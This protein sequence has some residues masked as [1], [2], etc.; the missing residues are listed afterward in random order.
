M[1][2]NREQWEWGKIHHY[3]WDHTFGKKSKLMGLYFNEG[4]YAAGGGS[5]TL[6]LTSYIWGKNL[7]TTIMPA[8]RLVVD[9]SKEEKVSLIS[10]PGQ[11]GHPSSSHYNDMIPFFL[12]G[13]T[14]PLPFKKETVEKQYKNVLKLLPGKKI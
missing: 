6:N 3:N 9:F 14:N 4:P 11:S 10:H 2:K 12:E 7:E 5:H 1:G 8:M 13:K